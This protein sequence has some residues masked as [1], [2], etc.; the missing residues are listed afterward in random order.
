MWF[1]S[2]WLTLKF[3]PIL[4]C[5]FCSQLTVGQFKTLGDFYLTGHGLFCP[6]SCPQPPPHVLLLI[7][8][9]VS[10]PF[11]GDTA[12]H[13]RELQCNST[14]LVPW[15]LNST[16][17]LPEKRVA[18]WL[19]SKS[20]EIWDLALFSF[21]LAAP[22]AILTA[23]T[24]MTRLFLKLMRSSLKA[25]TRPASCVDLQ[26]PGGLTWWCLREHQTSGCILISGIPG[27]LP[28]LIWWPKDQL[29]WEWVLL[30]NAALSQAS[31][32]PGLGKRLEGHLGLKKSVSGTSLVVQ[33]LRIRLQH[34]E[35]EFDPWSGN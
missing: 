14:D 25:T 24:W 32:Q 9:T 35:C 34:R 18:E 1:L 21:W 13:L 19:D 33:Q 30:R 17:R 26:A 31:S 22:K 10:L 16:R 15:S 20:V 29:E 3:N 27:S 28:T 4:F 6:R 12:E 8:A 23:L 11:S 5:Y 2:T 7:W